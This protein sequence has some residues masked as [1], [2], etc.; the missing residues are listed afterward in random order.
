[1]VLSIYNPILAVF[2]HPDPSAEVA[3]GRKKKPGDDLWRPGDDLWRPGDDL[4]RP[5]DD[6]WRYGDDLWR[7]GDDL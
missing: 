4:W 3:R 7:P 2:M 1:M 5:G 6:L